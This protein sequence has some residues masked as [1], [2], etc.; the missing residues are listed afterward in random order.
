M[1][2]HVNLFLENNLHLAC[3]PNWPN[4]LCY[5]RDDRSVIY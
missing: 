5:K 1:S 2:L 3:R 4:G